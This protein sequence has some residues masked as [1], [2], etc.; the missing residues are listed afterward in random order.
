MFCPAVDRTVA[1]RKSTQEKRTGETVILQ[2]EK[3][4]SRFTLI[5]RGENLLVYFVLA[6]F[7]VIIVKYVYL[8]GVLS[9]I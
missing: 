2:Q 9:Q 3:F 8:I 1:R 6:F 7:V 5:L 4:Y